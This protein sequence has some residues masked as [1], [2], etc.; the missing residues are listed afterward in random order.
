MGTPAAEQDT[1]ALED[2][3]TTRNAVPHRANESVGSNGE[4]EDIL[5]LLPKWL[6]PGVSPFIHTYV[7]AQI[8]ETLL[9][10]STNRP[11]DATLALT[12]IVIFTGSKR[13]FRL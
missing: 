1:L 3:T 10:L 5:K 6:Q 12:P 4:A 2:T 8:C 9:T 11:Q 7:L 13:L